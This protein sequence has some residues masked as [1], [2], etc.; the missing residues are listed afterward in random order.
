[1][2]DGP[3]RGFNTEKIN[4][5]I[6]FLEA[7]RDD[8]PIPSM[9]VP[10]RANLN[11]TD[12]FQALSTAL[13]DLKRL[14]TALRKTADVIE[15]A[16]VNVEEE[17]IPLSLQCGIRT[18]PGETIQ[19]IFELACEGGN[20]Q[21]PGPHHKFP[22]KLS[23]INRRFRSL[24]L[25]APYIWANL[26]TQLTAEGLRAFI[27]RSK[28]VDLSIYIY[29]SSDAHG[30]G[31][32][33]PPLED[34]LHTIIQHKERWSEFQYHRYSTNSDYGYSHPALDAYRSLK[35]PRLQSLAYKKY[36]FCS[37]WE[38]S[39]R[40]QPRTFF[41]S[42][43]MPKL[44]RFQGRNSPVPFKGIGKTLTT[45]TL[46]FASDGEDDARNLYG[47]L[48]A[49]ES[50][51]QL[52]H[53]TLK[54]SDECKCSDAPLVRS[55]LLRQLVSFEIDLAEALDWNLLTNL[56][57]VLKMPMLLHMSA[58][59]KVRGGDGDLISF[60]IMSA[61]QEYPKLTTF[62]L[63]ATH[64]IFH[65]S[66][67]VSLAESLPSLHEVS[68]RGLGLCE[69]NFLGR[70][71]PPSWRSLRVEGLGLADQKGVKKLVELM[72]KGPHWDDFRFYFVDRSGVSQVLPGLRL[73]LGDKLH[74]ES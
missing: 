61:A 10:I 3:L 6:S 54:L 39:H 23:H 57:S 18:L 22:I 46:H 60:A 2:V 7:S 69:G 17:A 40:R 26:S 34:F 58:I 21:D 73:L 32:G 71:Q 48:E 74:Y 35:L 56:L 66:V 37:I 15:N 53:L 24:A 72:A 52:K 51:P 27:T 41:A 1:M 62:A 29:D 8:I 65:D 59:V 47:S 31:H 45:C 4:K 36:N 30:S 42:W 20:G 55:I 38:G 28:S 44:Y 12:R 25:Q 63:E 50:I 11:P 33:E 67:L 64:M 43:T 9:D 16:I 19:R 49:L 70:R 13:I 14:K 68:F 5:L